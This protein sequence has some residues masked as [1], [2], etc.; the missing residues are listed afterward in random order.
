MCAVIMKLAAYL[1]FESIFQVKI[2]WQLN[3][4]VE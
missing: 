3:K 4:H 2:D 1:E